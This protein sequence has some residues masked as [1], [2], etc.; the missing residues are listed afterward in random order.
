MVIYTSDKVKKV[1][2]LIIA[3]FRKSLKH[4]ERKKGCVLCLA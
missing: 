1:F 2:E 4:Y 3:E